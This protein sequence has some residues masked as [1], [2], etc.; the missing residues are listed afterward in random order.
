MPAPQRASVPR[1][2]RS[3]RHGVRSSPESCPRL[4][5]GGV[6]FARSTPF[7]ILSPASYDP[8]LRDADLPTGVS[9]GRVMLS[10]AAHRPH[11]PWTTDYHHAAADHVAPTPTL[12]REAPRTV[13][14]G[15]ARRSPSHWDRPILTRP[16][17]RHRGRHARPLPAIPRPPSRRP[18]KPP[19][20]SPSFVPSGTTRRRRPPA[21]LGRPPHSPP[22]V[23]PRGPSPT[24]LTQPRHPRPSPHRAMASDQP[25]PRI[26]ILE[27][28]AARSRWLPNPRAV[29]RLPN[30]RAVRWLP[31]LTGFPCL[32]GSW[33]AK[34]GRRG[35]PAPV[36][37]PT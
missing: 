21:R 11:A 22:R 15:Y 9:R 26:L 14:P 23:A 18:G 12:L 24:G 20:G 25:L 17:A 6:A 10:V 36:S 1:R 7:V 29:R 33:V 16:P 2:G 8:P 28:A 3:S 13:A 30:P 35:P 31:G 5:N 19:G 37:N 27:A 32:P 4:P 34:C